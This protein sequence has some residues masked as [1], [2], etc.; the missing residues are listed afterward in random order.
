[1]L[2]RKHRLAVGGQSI[3]GW[4]T[5]HQQPRVALDVGADAVHFKN[6]D[7]PHTRSEMALP[8]IVGDRLLGALDVQ[9]IEETAFDEEDVAILR[10]MADQV[11]VAIDNAF[12]FS[13]ESAILEATSPLYRASRGIA[14]ATSLDDVLSSIVEH[15]A[16]PHIDRCSLNH[17]ADP[18]QGQKPFCLEVAAV[19]DRADDAPHPLGTQY[20]M[21]QYKLMALMR[22]ESAEPLVANDL[23][24]ESL[25]GR[26]DNKTLLLLTQKLGLRAVL[27]LP[28]VAAGRPTGLL[29]VSSRQSHTWTETE[30]RTFRSLSAQ[31]AG[32]VENARL[33]QRAQVRAERERLV[34][35]ITDQ[36][37]TS[38]EVDT[39]LRTAIGELGRALRASEGW[40]RLDVADEIG[41]SE[42][43]AQPSSWGQN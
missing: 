19:W 43:P 22:Q 25:D 11:A 32:A 4:V 31:V 14:L 24:A 21:D 2:A 26:V 7:L 9:S 17:Y 5:G 27:I 3:V 40:I 33:F 38:T 13:E 42:P 39:I 36:V 35:E 8:L 29:M 41:T 23:Y 16:G 20:P 37:R 30:L 18:S 1:M 15:A 6:P 10:L 34:A 12:R 28:L